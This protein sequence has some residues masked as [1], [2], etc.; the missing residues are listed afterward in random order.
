M[1]IILTKTCFHTYWN[2][3]SRNILIDNNTRREL[4]RILREAKKEGHGVETEVYLTTPA[5]SSET[6][7]G[8]YYIDDNVETKVVGKPIRIMNRTST[9]SNVH[10]L[11]SGDLL[12]QALRAI[13]KMDESLGMKNGL[14]TLE[15]KSDYPLRLSSGNGKISTHALIA[16]RITEDWREKQINKMM[17]D[18]IKQQ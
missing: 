17:M 13:N 16:P 7:I 12:S 14:I 10:E 8:V 1:N 15:Y 4:L 3:D 11:I 6:Y 2:S 9:D 5:H 18:N